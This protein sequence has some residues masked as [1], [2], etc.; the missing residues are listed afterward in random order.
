LRARTE[1]APAAELRERLLRHHPEGADEA[2]HL[3]AIIAFVDAHPNPFD[4]RIA[5]GHLTASAFVLSPDGR[6]V[7]LLHHRKLGRW[8]QPGGHAEAGE[9]VGEHVA[10]REARE[11]TGIETLAIFLPAPR[12]LDVDVHAIPAHGRDP[13][14]LHLD[15]R[16]LVIAP[17]DATLLRST[18]E[19]NSLR[20]F[21]WDEL[22]P[23]GLDSGLQRGLAK[24]RRTVI[25]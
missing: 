25:G 5:E 20:W 16:Y 7:L 17:A 11:E 1:A 13:A 8:L 14:H 10:L 2:A 18:N 9:S 21:G 15:L 24:A 23:L 22:G 12:P 3:A 19:T 4:R 6:S